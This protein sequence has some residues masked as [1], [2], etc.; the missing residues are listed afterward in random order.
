MPKVPVSRKTIA[1]GRRLSRPRRGRE[2]TPGRFFF[3]WIAVVKTSRPRRPRDRR[4]K[5]DDFAAGVVEIGL[6]DPNGVAVSGVPL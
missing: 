6:K 2:F 1:P 5:A 4:D 3:I